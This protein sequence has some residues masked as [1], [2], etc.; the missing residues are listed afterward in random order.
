MR[1][2]ETSTAVFDH[3]NNINYRGAWFCSRAELRQMV[4]Q[5]PLPS[6]DPNRAPQRG[7]IV[8]VAS[9]LGIVGRPSARKSDFYPIAQFFSQRSLV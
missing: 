9:Q 2:T 4:A 6:H 5:D 3:I 7:A 8:N 1:T